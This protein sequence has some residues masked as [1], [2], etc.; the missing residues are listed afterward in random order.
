MTQHRYCKLFEFSNSGLPGKIPKGER[1]LKSFCHSLPYFHIIVTTDVTAKRQSNHYVTYFYLAKKNDDRWTFYW[2]LHL[3]FAALR[4]CSAMAF[5]S[6][7]LAK[8]IEESKD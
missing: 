6:W 1:I 7:A 2:T 8:K 4:P 5:I 3:S